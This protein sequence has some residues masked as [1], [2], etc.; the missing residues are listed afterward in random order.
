MKFFDVL[1]LLKCLT[2]SGKWVRANGF[3]GYWV[4]FISK[5]SLNTTI[6]IKIANHWGSE[7]FHNI[8]YNQ[9]HSVSTLVHFELGCYRALI[10]LSVV[11][12][13]EK[14]WQWED[15]LDSQGIK[16]WEQQKAS[17]PIKL[18]LPSYFI[19]TNM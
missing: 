2:G 15:C 12:I 17:A 8:F 19:W 16:R 7:T 9:L 10:W 3:N 6:P 5:G 13:G 1:N 14:Q 18:P 4:M 11:E